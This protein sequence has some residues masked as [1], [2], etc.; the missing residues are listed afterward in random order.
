MNQDYL[1]IY[2]K[3]PFCLLFCERAY[4]DDGSLCLSEGRLRDV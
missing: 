2:L 1:N 3:A 4:V